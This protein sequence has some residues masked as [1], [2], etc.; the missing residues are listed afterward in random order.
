MNTPEDMKKV[1]HKSQHCQRNWDLTKEIPQEHLD[2][3]LEAVTQ[4]PSKQNKAF[5]KVHFITN[6]DIIEKAHAKT[7]GFGNYLTINENTAKFE[8]QTNSQVLANLLVVF[9]KYEGDKIPQH[10]NPELEFDTKFAENRDRDTAVGIAAGYLNLTG[11]LLGYSTGCCGCF[12]TDEMKEVLGLENEPL[13][14][15]GV[16]HPDPSRN[17]RIHHADP[18]FKFPTIKKSPIP[19]EVVK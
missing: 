5:Y 11:S 3:M 15:M 17:R 9:E 6:R 19:V 13:L 7:V 4:C 12:K 2:T 16:G 1:I 8:P 10:P 14:L 18:S